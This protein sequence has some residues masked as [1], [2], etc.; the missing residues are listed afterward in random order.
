VATRELT[1]DIVLRTEKAVAEIKSMLAKSNKEAEKQGKTAGENYAKGIKSEIDKLKI[2]ILQ[3]AKVDKFKL[4]Q[5]KNEIQAGLASGQLNNTEALGLFNSLFG[6]A[7]DQG[8]E[9]AKQFSKAFKITINDR[10]NKA[11]GNL[12]QPFKTLTKNL[13]VDIKNGFNSG[14]NKIGETSLK[15]LTENTKNTTAKIIEN[16]KKIPSQIGDS[17]VWVKKNILDFDLN[18]LIYKDFPAF[19]KQVFNNFKE[20]A[21]GAFENLKKLPGFL[22]N[23]D[24]N[25]V[26][27]GLGGFSSAI[28][29]GIKNLGNFG[30]I[31]G[32]VTSQ[33]I[34]GFG[35]MAS[36]IAGGLGNALASAGKGALNLAGNLAGGVT[37]AGVAGVVAG[38]AGLFGLGAFG[39]NLASQIQSTRIS[40]ETML[41]SAENAKGLMTEI[42]AFAKKTPFNRL[43]L[44]D[45]SKQLIGAGIAQKDMIS[46]LNKLGNVAAGS[47]APLQNIITNYGQIRAS[48]RAYT[49]DLMQFSNFGIP[50]W[51][52]LAKNMGITVEQL[53]TGI[54]T[55]KIKVNFQEVDKVLKEMTS[56]G[57]QYFDL[58]Q[59]KSGTFEGAMSNLQDTFESMVLK[60]MGVDDTGDI[61]Q[62]GFFDMAQDKALK[63]QG[64]LME[65]EAQIGEWGGKVFTKIGEGMQMAWTN[66]VQPVLLDLQDWFNNGGKE[67]IKSFMQNG[68]Q[69]IV[70]GFTY[71]KDVVYPDAKKKL[72]EFKAY[73]ASEQGKKDIKD[74]TDFMKGL[75]EAIKFVAYWSGEAIKG[76]DGLIGKW[77]ELSNA[78][79]LGDSSF[80][81]AGV[82]ANPWVAIS[83]LIGGK[84]ASGGPV[85][86]GKLYEVGE[87]NRAEMLMMNGRQYMI[88]GNKGQV[89]NQSQIDNRQINSGNTN[90]FY[91]FT[92]GG[93][94]FTPSYMT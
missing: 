94:E 11:L 87:N 32:D 76:I 37:T 6:V 84:R 53:R 23:L 22:F 18:K 14:L 65:N 73:M 51:E 8:A 24:L 82:A 52:K 16:I 35:K 83:Q 9:V 4:N 92:N 7:K 88:P 70:K 56:S 85:D 21:S 20:F 12:T 10:I 33:G 19:T 72:D 30:S 50:I 49:R 93:N 45:Y 3:G 67:A 62:G 57:G 81:F 43:E 60:F 75:W 34:N 27:S 40:L 54:D 15:D 55:Q 89:L 78:T 42:T 63:F 1:Y 91:N 5:L 44:F 58:M 71:F 17:L 25:K 86:P 13:S 68:W 28:Q 64:W 66:M 69:E 59:K 74:F 2:D 31:L 36:S 48:N 47:G 77:R 80:S 46:T 29:G 26:F 39:L 90:N 38:G 79:K 61:K 41:G